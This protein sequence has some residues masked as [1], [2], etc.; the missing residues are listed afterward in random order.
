MEREMNSLSKAALLTLNKLL[1]PFGVSVMRASTFER[2]NKAEK[3]V[4]QQPIP[5]PEMPA[6]SAI[7]TAQ[8]SI[9]AP[10]APIMPAA[11]MSEDGLPLHVLNEIFR[12]RH[13]F[14]V[15]EELQLHISRYNEVVGELYH[16]CTSFAFKN[17]PSVPHRKTLLQCLL[18][19]N[20][21]EA[22][23]LI[24]YLQCAL[25]VDGDVCEFGCAHGSTSVLLANEITSTDRTLWLFDSFKGLSKPTKE[26]Q[27]IDDIFNLGSMAAYEGTMGYPDTVVRSKLKALGFPE[28]RTHIVPGFIQSSLKQAQLPEQVCFAY[29]DFD[30]YEPILIALN[31]LADRVPVG[32]YIVVDDYGFLSAG[33]QKATDEFVHAHESTFRMELPPS[34]AGKFAVLSKYA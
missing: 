17:I 25:A 7:P 12:S 9:S 3:L 23:W 22:I 34:W 30:L 14:S 8:A 31:F 20:I 11:I 5:M 6:A 29:V 33:A 26:D 10:A 15:L 18:G 28:S 27:L 16:C 21:S 2:L 19:T 32:G 13:G 4:W 1:K 24:N